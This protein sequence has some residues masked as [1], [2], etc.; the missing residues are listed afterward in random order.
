MD[1]A[2]SARNDKRRRRIV[3]YVCHG[4]IELSEVIV[5]AADQEMRRS[6]KPPPMFS[7]LCVENYL[8]RLTD[9]EPIRNGIV[10]GPGLAVLFFGMEYFRTIDGAKITRFAT[11]SRAHD[12]LFERN[13]NT[14]ETRPYC[15]D[16]SR[17]DGKFGFGIE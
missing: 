3:F 15:D 6:V 5:S 4:H 11:A 17:G 16:L 8:D 9:G 7:V 10:R 14:K 1:Q 13:D 2:V 12:V